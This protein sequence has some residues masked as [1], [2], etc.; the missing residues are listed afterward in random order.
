MLSSSILLLLGL[1]SAV[2]AQTTYTGCHNHSTVEYDR[3]QEMRTLNPA[4]NGIDIATVLMARK[5]L[6]SPTRPSTPPH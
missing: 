4:H 5:L 1:A 6:W 2:K 3:P